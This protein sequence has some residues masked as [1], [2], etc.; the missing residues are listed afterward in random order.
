SERRSDGG[1]SRWSAGPGRP[2]RRRSD[3]HPFARA[4]PGDDDRRDR[5]HRER[6][7]EESETGGH[8]RR[9]GEPARLAEAKRDHGRDRVS[10]RLE[11]VRADEEGGTEDDRDGDRL[12]ESPPEAEHRA[13][14]DP[15]L[16]EREDDRAAHP[17]PRRSKRERALL[18]G[19]RSL[20]EHL[21]H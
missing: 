12:S 18:F 2:V 21:P 20:G 1:A 10:A 9:E 6:E 3:L 13:A 17:P 8:E 4:R 19:G 15:A 16:A 5:V 11:D 7:S 14:D